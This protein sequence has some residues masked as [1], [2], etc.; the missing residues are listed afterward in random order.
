MVRIMV[1]I[2]YANQHQCA[3][4]LEPAPIR[5]FVIVIMTIVLQ[6]GVKDIYGDGVKN[7]PS[8]NFKLSYLKIVHLRD[9]ERM[10]NLYT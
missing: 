2:L 5:C 6:V 10:C 8:I 1:L 3:F 7:H 9:S 4:H